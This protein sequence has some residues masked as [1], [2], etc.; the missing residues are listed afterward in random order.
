[1]GRLSEQQREDLKTKIGIFAVLVAI[2]AP[3]LLGG[4]LLPQV[5]GHYRKN[6][7]TDPSAP[8]RLYQAAALMTATMR[9][10]QARELLEEWY[11]LFADDHANGVD[12]SGP[13][14]DDSMFRDY[15]YLPWVVDKLPDGR[16][17]PVR[18]ADRELIGKVLARLA[19]LYE[20]ERQ[21]GNSN[22]IY[23]CMYHLWPDGSLT[24]NE[25]DDGRKRAL[26]R[27]FSE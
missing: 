8:E 13:L 22:H 23:A 24:F 5:V 16:P 27:S 1:M 9:K 20:D 11:V 10:E 4:P 2:G 19:K 25:A 17:D 26:Q 14:E 6:A 15:Y 21:Y 7:K 12:F 3:I 18:V